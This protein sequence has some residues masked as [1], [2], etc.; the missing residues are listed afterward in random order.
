MEQKTK[1]LLIGKAGQGKSSLAN[2]LLGE[3][4]FKVSDL[5][6]LAIQG[7]MKYEINGLTIIDTPGLGYKDDIKH[8]KDSIQFISNDYINGIIVVMNVQENRITEDIEKMI[9]LI[10]NNFNYRIFNHIS[11]V[12][13]NYYGEQK[14]KEKLKRNKKRFVEKIMN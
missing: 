9:K 13:T 3:N 8:F 12:F 1:I 4:I 6:N 11:F 14:Q 2:F 10:C 7:I 5:P